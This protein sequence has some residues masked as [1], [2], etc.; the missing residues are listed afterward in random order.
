MLYWL[1]TEGRANMLYLL[2]PF[3][4]LTIILTLTALLV[5]GVGVRRANE[6][7]HP[8]RGSNPLRLLAHLMLTAALIATFTIIAGELAIQPGHNATSSPLLQRLAGAPPRVDVQRL[9]AFGLGMTGLVVIGNLMLAGQFRSGSPLREWLDSLRSPRRR[10][11]E[12]GSSH[13]C[14]PREYRRYRRPDPEGITLLGSFWGERGSRI[15]AGQGQ[16][17]LSGEDAARGILAIGGP[18]SGKSQ[19]VILPVIADRMQARH[20]LIVADPQ[21]ELTGHILRLAAVT[22]HLVAIHDPT[23]TD[24]PRFNLMQNITAVSDAR[25]IADVLVPSMPGESRFWSDSAAALLA[26]CLLR[27]ETLGEIYAALADLNRLAG[28]L[29]TG[30]DD[31]ARLLASSFIASVYGDNKVASSTVATLATALTGWAAA[32]VRAT[33]SGSDFTALSLVRRPTLIVLTCPG[34]MRAVYAPYLG[35]VLRKL[36]LDLDSIGERS[37][38]P[39]PVPVALV[40]DEFPALGKLDSLVA[41]VNLV[42]KRRIS[43]VVAAQTRGQFHLL[44]GQAGTEA[45]FT[46]LATQIVFGGGDADTAAYYSKASGQATELSPRKRADGTSD[47]VPRGRPLL[48]SDEVQTPPWGNS[49]IFA[50]YVDEN[51][52]AQVILAARLTRFY[53]RDDWRTRLAA[54]RGRRPRLLKRGV[55]SNTGGQSVR[56][57]VKPPGDWRRHHEQD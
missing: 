22:G 1:F 18:G 40:M 19:A 51:D 42:R 6:T 14:T 31:D 9:L 5:Q 27:F 8:I 20:S 24:T 13:F 17:C 52:A 10:R 30:P 55:K 38:G 11:G 32:T 37:G 26:A 29:A 3:W 56:M 23:R 45:L 48:T 2:A 43:I 16:F 34:R 46:G 33:T 21:G 35:A 49:L 57:L 41:D 4:C 53:E 28:Q 47:A 7:P 12:A 50:R 54:A 15:D 44:Y 25:A 36:M 39:L